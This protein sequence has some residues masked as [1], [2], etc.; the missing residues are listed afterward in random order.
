MAQTFKTRVVATRTDLILATLDAQTAADRAA[1]VAREAYDWA[2]RLDAG[3]DDAVEASRAAVRARH[4]AEAAANAADQA[5]AQD[6]ARLAWAALAS[7]EEASARV[8]AA[9]AEKLSAA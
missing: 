3:A 8:N 4:A 7:A 9:V 6:L 1:E 5:A 2:V